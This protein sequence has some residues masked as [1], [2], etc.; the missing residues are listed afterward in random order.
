MGT[1][2]GQRYG[3]DGGECIRGKMVIGNKGATNASSRWGQCNGSPPRDRH[4]SAEYGRQRGVQHKTAARVGGAAAA[5]RAQAARGATRTQPQGCAYPQ[6]QWRDCEETETRT[7]Q[8]ADTRR[9]AQ[10]RTGRR[11]VRRDDCVATAGRRVGTGCPHLIA[12][13]QGSCDEDSLVVLA[14]AHSL[15]GP[16]GMQTA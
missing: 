10:G 16:W 11:Q 1:L 15:V 13:T 4:H 3:A 6:R 12:G 7:Q 5:H 14:A 2:A 8:N 9:S